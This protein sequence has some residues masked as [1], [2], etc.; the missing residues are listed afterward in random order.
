MKCVADLHLHSKYSRATSINMDLDE[1]ARWAKLKGIDILG[2]GDFT[3]PIWLKELNEKLTPLGNGLFEYKGTMFMLTSEVSNIYQAGGRVRKIHQCIFSPSFEIVHQINDGLKKGGRLEADGRPILSLTAPETVEAVMGASKDNFILPAHA[4]T[5][6]FGV[7]GSKS[8]FDSL[9]ECYEDTLKHIYAIETGLSSDPEMNWRLSALDRYALISN[10]DAH[11][12]PKLGREANVFDLDGITYLNITNAIKKKD[13]KHFLLTYEFFPQEGKYHADGHRN[14]DVLFYPKES[15]RHNNICPV[16]R[17]PLTVGVLHRVDDLADREPGY[18]PPDA[19]PFEHIIPL[20]E[21][22][23]KCIGKGAGTKGV[24][25]E[26]FRIV[27]YFGSEFNALHAKEDE[28]SMATGEHIA[29]GISN[30]QTGNVK[31]VPGYDGVYGKID[32][33]GMGGIEGK[34]RRETQRTLGDF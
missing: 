22:I 30:A 33:E 2:T 1:M 15:K 34:E 20:Q 26:Y 21:L 4:W 23:S 25:T 24:I 6:Y 29:K 14:C 10:S 18:K 31:I 16:C 11:S 9:E 19:I 3:H 12:A 5:P 8:G 32:I 17:R 7:F 13:R 27:K 28:L